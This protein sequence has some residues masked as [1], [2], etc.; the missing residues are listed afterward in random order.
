[1]SP[2]SYPC[3][4]SLKRSITLNTMLYVCKTSLRHSH[5][6]RRMQIAIVID[7][8]GKTWKSPVI[9]KLVEKYGA[10]EC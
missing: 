6:H 9:K 4:H 1:M 7:R 2:K 8:Y 3:P 5:L 10:H